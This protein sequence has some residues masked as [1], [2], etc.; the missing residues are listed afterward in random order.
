MAEI[1]FPSKLCCPRCGVV[2]YQPSEQPSW[3]PSHAMGGKSGAA[4]WECPQCQQREGVYGLAPTVEVQLLHSQ[5][6]PI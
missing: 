2:D 1:K 6:Y 3:P 4:R 5:V